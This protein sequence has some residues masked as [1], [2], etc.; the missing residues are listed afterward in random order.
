MVPKTQQEKVV[1]M[2]ANAPP[3]FGRIVE[4]TDENE[5]I[6]I[7]FVSVDAPAT[8]SITT[9]APTSTMETPS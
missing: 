4:I 1:P 7:T 2:G 3:L 5:T 6:I 9:N 8:S